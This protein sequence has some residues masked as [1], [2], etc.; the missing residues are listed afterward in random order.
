MK[1]LGMIGGTGWVSSME[2]YKLINEEVNRRLGGLHAA[3]CILYSLNF[4]EIDALGLQ[5]NPDAVYRLV[6]GAAESLRRGGADG[7]MLCANTTHMFA[8][9]LEKDISLSLIHIGAAT[10]GAIRSKGFDTVA[11]LGTRFTMEMDFYRDK[12]HEAGITMLVPDKPERDYIHEAILTELLHN[13]FLPQTKSRFLQII[14]KLTHDGAQGIVL[15]C[16]EIPLLIRQED[17]DVPVFSTTGIH[18][19]AAVDFMLGKG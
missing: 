6:L 17:V 1:K 14:R 18:A 11:L 2:Y 9:R 5:K 7:L 16:T 8:N 3:E 10:A 15:G 4:A 19:M 13:K 12:L